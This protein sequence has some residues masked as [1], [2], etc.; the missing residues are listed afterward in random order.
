MMMPLTQ[1]VS[2]E[3]VPGMLCNVVS[4]G[5]VTKAC[6]QGI[7]RAWRSVLHHAAILMRFVATQLYL[8]KQLSTV[9]H[10]CHTYIPGPERLPLGRSS[11]R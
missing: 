2:I 7:L 10:V 4:P 9:L 6:D 5:R 8:T 3:T 11:V 1:S